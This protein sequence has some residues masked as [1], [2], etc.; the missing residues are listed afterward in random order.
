[1]KFNPL[2][3]VQNTPKIQSHVARG[4][5]AQRSQLDHAPMEAERWGPV[6]SW[7]QIF[8]FVFVSC[9]II[10]FKQS[11]QRLTSS[12]QVDNKAPIEN[13]A[14][15]QIL[16]SCDRVHSFQTHTD[17][18]TKPCAG[19]TVEPVEQRGGGGGTVIRT[20]FH[21]DCVITVWWFK[22]CDHHSPPHSVE[23]HH[24]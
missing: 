1:M 19:R 8:F 12:T 18:G 9:N 10:W 14:T 22:A 21:E 24:I 7:L 16:G 20:I 3:L 4:S 23:Y 15:P 13:S 11:Q 2:C 5:P 6:P 17:L